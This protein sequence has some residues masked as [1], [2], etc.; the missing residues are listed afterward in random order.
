MGWKGCIGI[1]S[2]ARAQPKVRSVPKT[3]E[4]ILDAPFLRDDY[5]LNLLDWSVRVHAELTAVAACSTLQSR[6]PAFAHSGLCLLT[7]SRSVGGD[8]P[9]LHCTVLHCTAL[10]QF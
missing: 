4:R 8:K 9:A 7:Y 10:A 1:G 5:Y 6:V 2:C 3:P